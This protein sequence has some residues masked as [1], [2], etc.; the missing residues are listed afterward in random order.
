M[1]TNR[2]LLS[3]QLRYVFSNS[4]FYQEK[5]RSSG[6]SQKDAK[7]IDSFKNLPFTEKNEI[8]L[9]Q[10]NFPPFGRLAIKNSSEIKRIHKTSGT[11]GRPLFIALT[12]K[13]IQANVQSGK[14]AFL[15]AG[16]TPTDR[17]IHCLNYCMW[18][19]GVTDHLSL[20]ATGAAV[21]PFG[22]GNTKQL[23]ETMQ[24]LKPNSISCTPSY[25]SRLEVVL[26]E[27]FNLEP[28]DLC[29]KKGFFG[30]EGGLQIPD[31][32]KKIEDT[33]NIQA[34][35]ANYGMADVLSIF[36]AE[37]EQR[38][39][40]HFHGQGIIHLEIIDPKTGESLPVE[41]GVTGEMVL[42]NLVREAQPLLRYRTSD[43]ITILGTDTCSCRRN[44]IRFKIEDRIDDMIVVRGINVYASAIAKEIYGYPEFFSGEFE[45]VL[46]S[47]PP[48]ERPLINI[49]L[50]KTCSLNIEALEKIFVTKC[51]QKLNFTPKL[52][53]ISWGKFPRNEGKT[54][55]IRK[56]F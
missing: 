22:V 53:F 9:D 30:G 38:C 26:Q 1:Q 28:Q 46:T 39:G 15:C 19:G 33:W 35:D 42:T 40:L 2:Q 47:P 32:R 17:V 52:N 7:K 24:H 51:H 18:A 34:L 14:K 49:E 4:P 5:I 23:I 54:K 13:D 41:E 25:M 16:L 31:V 29:L 50:S 43:I 10:I 56:I 8:I 44:S 11:S 20:E 55:H 48:Y 21:I 36:G 6:I 45:I 3:N 27:E 37:C 12:E